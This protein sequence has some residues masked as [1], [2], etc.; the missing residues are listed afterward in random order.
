MEGWK[1]GVGYLAGRGWGCVYMY[2]LVMTTVIYNSPHNL[3]HIVFV[4]ADRNPYLG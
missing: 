1:D 2:V 3:S 4:Y